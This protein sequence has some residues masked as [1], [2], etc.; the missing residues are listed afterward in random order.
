MI[1]SLGLGLDTRLSFKLDTAEQGAAASFRIALAA[2]PE[3]SSLL[4]LATAAGLLAR[5]A[6]RAKR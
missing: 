1:V 3:A 2:V 4:L 5:R 6:R